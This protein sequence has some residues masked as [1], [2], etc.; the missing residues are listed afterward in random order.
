MRVQRTTRSGGSGDRRVA[1]GQH[2]VVS[3]AQLSE[4][5]LGRGRSV[6]ESGSD[7]CVRC[8]EASTRSWAPPPDEVRA[9]DGRRSCLWTGRRLEPLRGGRALGH[10][11]RSPARGHSAAR[12]E[13][14]A[15]GSASIGPTSPPTRSPSTTAFR[16][17]RC[18]A[19]FSTSVPS[20][21]ATSCAA[22]FGR[23]S[24]SA[25]GPAGLGPLIER[26]PRKPGIP[27]LKA[28]VEEAQRGLDIVRSELEE[29][30]QAF[31]LNAGLPRPA[32]QRPHRGHARWTAPGR[33]SAS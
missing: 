31:L 32:H 6:T 23:P 22:R 3:R 2:G 28:V 30:F 9:L 12:E 20:F 14:R 27:I 24:S 26:Y 5:G 16:P 29:R 19:R 15:P 33:T 18:P 25:H 7:G 11:W 1:E 4:L 21:S 8:T 10:P 17:R 13:G